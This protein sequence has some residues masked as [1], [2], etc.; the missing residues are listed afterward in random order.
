MIIL[1]LYDYVSIGMCD[2]LAAGI[3]KMDREITGEWAPTWENKLFREAW[4]S[5][6]IQKAGMMNLT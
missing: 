3:M 5:Q 2:S 6:R 1:M 4:C